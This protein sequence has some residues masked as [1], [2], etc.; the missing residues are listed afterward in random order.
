VLHLLVLLSVG[1]LSSVLCV[2]VCESVCVSV[3]FRA[4]WTAKN[5]LSR[6]VRTST[7]VASSCTLDFRDDF[8]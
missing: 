7:F 1:K 6:H 4:D 3:E 5:F 8:T 2:C